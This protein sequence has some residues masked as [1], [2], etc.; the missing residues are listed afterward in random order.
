AAAGAWGDCGWLGD[1]ADIWGEQHGRGLGSG[2]AAWGG[3]AVVPGAGGST[4]V[5]GGD[6]KLPGDAAV[7]SAEPGNADGDDLCAAGGIRIR[8]VAGQRRRD[9]LFHGADPWAGADG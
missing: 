9:R 8:N 1:F 4:D 6:S 3:G 2:A 7:A 5:Q